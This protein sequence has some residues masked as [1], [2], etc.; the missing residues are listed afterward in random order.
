MNLLKMYSLLKM[1]I[2][3]CHVS[4]PKGNES[5]HFFLQQGFIIIQKEFHHFFN[6]GDDF[7]GNIYVYSKQP[8]VIKEMVVSPNIHQ[9]LIVQTA[10]V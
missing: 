9:T 7:Q 6:G 10:R 2:F 4:L 1:W 5:Q 8:L 3:H